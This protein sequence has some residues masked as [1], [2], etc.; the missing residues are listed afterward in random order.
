[1]QLV[2]DPGSEISTRDAH[3]Q[4]KLR[5]AGLQKGRRRPLLKATA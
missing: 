4:P 5:D 3:H 2:T 1:L